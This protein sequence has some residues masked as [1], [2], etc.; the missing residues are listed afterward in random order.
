MEDVRKAYTMWDRVRVPVLGV[1]ENMSTFVCNCGEEHSLFGQGGGVLLAKRFGVEL[2]AQ[3]PLVA[4]VREGGDSGRPV[5]LGGGPVVDKVASVF[6]KFAQR[7]AQLIEVRSH[8]GAQTAQ[9]TSNT[10]HAGQAGHSHAG[11]GHAGHRHSGGIE[12]G[13]FQ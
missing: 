13:T 4:A 11:H 2:L 9:Q 1:V 10:G 6:R 5:V 8:K 7:V 3:V 12:I